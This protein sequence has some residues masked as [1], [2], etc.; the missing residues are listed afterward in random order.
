MFF[1]DQ[2][3]VVSILNLELFSFLSQVEI[4]VEVCF[5][6]VPQV[7]RERCQNGTPVP[8][9]IY[10]SATQSN[11][12]SR[13]MRCM[14]STIFV[15]ALQ[16]FPPHIVATWSFCDFTS[17]I[18]NGWAVVPMPMWPVSMVLLPCH[19]RIGL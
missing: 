18:T 14:T 7:S 8:E 12:L 3:V 4:I 13:K 1:S 15:G 11:D 6:T 5:R 16:F 17:G 19:R 10:K 2:K 9:N